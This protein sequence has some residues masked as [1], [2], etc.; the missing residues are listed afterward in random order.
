MPCFDPLLLKNQNMSFFVAVVF[1]FFFFHLLFRNSFTTHPPSQPL[2]HTKFP[3]R[4]LYLSFRSPPR[5]PPRYVVI[6]LFAQRDATNGFCG[7]I[8]GRF[9]TLFLLSS[10]LR[11]K[12]GL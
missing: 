2:P 11:D 7:T 3:P 5:I 4:F 12:R 8:R 6:L 9:P 1:F 10:H